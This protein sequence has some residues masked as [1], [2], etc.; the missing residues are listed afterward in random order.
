MDPFRPI[1]MDLCLLIIRVYFLFKHVIRFFLLTLTLT[2]IYLL[3]LFCSDG[4]W[5]WCC[6]CAYCGFRV[7]KIASVFFFFFLII[8]KKRF[9][10]MMLIM[11]HLVLSGILDQAKDPY[12]Y[13]S[14]SDF[15]MLW[16]H[17]FTC[18]CIRGF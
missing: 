3:I 14:M 2:L 11:L 15:T 5:T 7:G 1:R 6:D 8:Y 16:F 18:T 10:E 13:P 4:F 9:T 12:P 17:V